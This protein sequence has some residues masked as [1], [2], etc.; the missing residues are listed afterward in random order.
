L[1]SE[2]SPIA[3]VQINEK[4]NYGDFFLI[5]AVSAGFLAVLHQLRRSMAAIVAALSTEA[6]DATL[7][8]ATAKTRAPS[9]GNRAR[10]S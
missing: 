4:A 10:R 9:E 3:C 1:K 2:R 7:R 5:L 6:M 8:H